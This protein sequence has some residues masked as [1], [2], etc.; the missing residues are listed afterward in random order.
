MVTKRLLAS[1]AVAATLLAGC[2]DSVNGT[3][4][5]DGPV[6]FPTTASALAAKLKAGILTIR[7]THLTLNESIAGQTLSGAGDE[8]VAQGK[9][10]ALSLRLS[11]PQLGTL[12]VLR[13]G[14]DTYLKLPAAQRTS[15]KP[16]VLVTETS[17]NPVVRAMAG[18]LSTADQLAGLDSAAIF[19]AATRNLKYLGPTTVAGASVGHYSLTVDVTRLPADFPQKQLLI[20]SGLTKLPVQVWIDTSGRLRK[21]TEQITV[22]SQT[23][24]SVVTLGNFDAP[25]HIS[26]P[27]ADQ[28][29]TN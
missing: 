25:V 29:D 1:L 13:T 28:V 11:V 3:P 22:A 20:T 18:S 12:Q 10:S 23:V 26:A 16:W 19:V 2:A 9:V 17:S 7:S 6:G 14:S 8:V 15:D 4:A 27:P 24:T 5:T 21:L